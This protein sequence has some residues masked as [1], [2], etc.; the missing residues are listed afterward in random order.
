M[1]AL[2]KTQAPWQPRLQIIE[3]VRDHVYSDLRNKREVAAISVH[4]ERASL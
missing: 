2:H 4:T 3:A 1:G